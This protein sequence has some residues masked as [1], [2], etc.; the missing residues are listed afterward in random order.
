MTNSQQPL[1]SE[2]LFSPKPVTPDI[3]THA[4]SSMSGG[5]LLISF[6]V[7]YSVNMVFDL[8]FILRIH[9]SDSRQL[10]NLT[11]FFVLDLQ[12]PSP[13]NAVVNGSLANSTRDQIQALAYARFLLLFILSACQPRPV[14]FPALLLDIQLFIRPS[15][16]EAEDTLSECVLLE[17][18]G[19]GADVVSVCRN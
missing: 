4:V 2:S 6:H 8:N 10:F 1:Q 12:S 11:D 18:F 14:L 16:W 19:P 13:I 7:L 9:I 3:V 17:G 5:L 15:A